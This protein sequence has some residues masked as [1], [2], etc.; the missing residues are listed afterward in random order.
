MLGICCS[1]LSRGGDL[2]LF[3]G[4]LSDSICNY[5]FLKFKRKR[6]ARKKNFSLY[7]PPSFPVFLSAS[8]FNS[9]VIMNKKSIKTARSTIREFIESFFF[10]VEAGQ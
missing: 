7:K 6:S 3:E 4:V 8:P 10:Y 9:K 2:L 1:V 5:I